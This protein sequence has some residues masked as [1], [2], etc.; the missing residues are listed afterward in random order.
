LGWLKGTHP[1]RPP[2]LPTA[3]IPPESEMVDK[4]AIFC[5]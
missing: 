1:R 3:G 2:E 5:I 4:I